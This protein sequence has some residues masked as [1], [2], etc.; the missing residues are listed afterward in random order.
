[1][2]NMQLTKNFDLYEFRSNIPSREGYPIVEVPSGLI[3]NAQKLANNLQI[4]RDYIQQPIN[5]N[6]GYRTIDYNKAVGGS[7]NSFH[8]RC[9][10]ADLR[11]ELHPIKLRNIIYDLMM[12]GKI[13]SGGLKAYKTF[14]HYDIRGLLCY[15]V[16]LK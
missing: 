12:I 10:A 13:E 8:L 9:L 5:I 6:S 14:V 3:P 2:E 1:M 15:L 11:T 7:Q 4:I 16:N